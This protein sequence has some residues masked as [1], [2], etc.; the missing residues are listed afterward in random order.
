MWKFEENSGT[1]GTRVEAEN[2]PKKKTIMEAGVRAPGWNSLSEV[3]RCS[4]EIT[5]P[6]GLN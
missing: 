5:A 1:S 6:W 2:A 3:R 4:I